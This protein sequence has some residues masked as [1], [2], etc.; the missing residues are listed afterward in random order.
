MWSRH[1]QFFLPIIILPLAFLLFIAGGYFGLRITAKQS[2]P[3]RKYFADEFILVGKDASGESFLLE[4]ALCRKQDV[5]LGSYQ[6][7]Y[8]AALIYRDSNVSSSRNMFYSFATVSPLG[9]LTRFEHTRAADLSSRESYKFSITLDGQTIDLDISD[10]QADFL[11]KNSSEYTKYMSVGKALVTIAGRQFPVEA[12]TTTYYSTDYAPYIF[13]DGQ[14]ALRSDT[15][16]FAIWDQEHNFYYLD[17]STVLDPISQYQS[18]TWVL[19]KNH[20]TGATYKSYGA[21]LRIHEE[22]GKASSW[23]VDLQN[24]TPSHFE[25]RPLIHKTD[26]PRE[27]LLSGH[28]KDVRGHREVQG[29]YFHHTYGG[30]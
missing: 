11:V 3:F 14:D 5:L 16:V 29:V 7:S 2:Q 23:T 25:L 22:G 24:A 28:V 30:Q 26:T 4:V 19:E 1:K 20:I 13:F 6:H 21:A 15:H 17:T 9:A 27:G 18:H 12:L 8:S 10:L